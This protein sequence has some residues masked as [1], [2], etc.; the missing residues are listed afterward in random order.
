MRR[1][2]DQQGY[3]PSGETEILDNLE[4]IL[5]TMRHQLGNSVNAI[6]VTL[7]VLKQNFD[8]FNDGKKKDYL[9]RGA[10]L[11]ER[12]QVLIEAMKSYS[13]FDVREQHDIDLTVLWEHL[14]SLIRGRLDTA[15]VAFRQLADLEPGMVRG[16]MMA[17]E[18]VVISL[19]ENALEA[20]ETVETP[21]LELEAV[22]RNRVLA[23]SIRDNGCGIAETDLRRI[24][25]P[26]FTTKPG[27]AGM[28]LSIAHKLLLKM[29]GGMTID[30]IPDEGTC[31]R[32]WL[33]AA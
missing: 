4:V 32:I 11:L 25:I 23:I 31:V 22:A 17:L 20:M 7:D 2:A 15:G 24:R 5:S 1:T 9:D 30:S 21:Y 6:K 14:S 26:L 10:L 16:N 28:G 3:D 8:L 29:D 13:R 27:R 12:Q 33:T 19:L 18:K